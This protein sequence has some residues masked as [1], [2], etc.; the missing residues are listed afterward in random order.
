MRTEGG[1]APREVARRDGAPA[2]RPRSALARGAALAL[3]V[4]ALLVPDLLLPPPLLSQAEG[5]EEEVL[6]R[7][8]RQS[9]ERLGEIRRERE[10]LRRELDD[11]AG[12]VHDVSAEIENLEAQIGTSSSVIAELRVQIDALLEQLT[13]TTRD[14][15]GTRDRLT[16]RKVVLRERLREIYKRGPLGTIQVLLAANSFSDLINR[17]KYLHKVALYDRLLVQEVGR[18]ETELA[19]QRSRLEGDLERLSDLSAEKRRELDDLERLERQRQRRLRSYAARRSQARSRLAQLAEEEERLR[20]TVAELE[21]ARRA[22]ERATGTA[23]TSTLRTSDLGSLSWPV[24]GEIVYR[25]GTSREE[26]G[27]TRR[28]GIGIGAPPGSPV[29][30]VEA[31]TV[32]YAGARGLY[33]QSVILGHG[34]GYYSVY[35]YMRSLSVGEGDRVSAGQVLGAVG[36]LRSPEGPH[37]EFQ[38]WEP[39]SGGNPRP[40]DPVRWL[41]GRS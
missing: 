10:Q 37:L 39:A 28:D 21:R 7:Q 12:R 30:A 3:L 19:E 4:P 32:E 27:T 9:Q 23:S 15:L 34:G 18:L 2:H 25:F 6:R 17:Y 35:L 36:G 11:L 14:M 22:A 41:R 13:F 29:R 26:E 31:G 5:S 8:I 40:V 24:E 16:E 33:G 20:N 38:I 1:A